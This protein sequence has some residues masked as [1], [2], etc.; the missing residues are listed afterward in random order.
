MKH[1]LSEEVEPLKK[2]FMVIV[3]LPQKS[4]VVH[5]PCRGCA[6][7]TLPEAVFVA[8]LLI[9]RKLDPH[10]KGKPHN[11]F[12]EDAELILKDHALVEVHPR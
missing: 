1:W 9:R 7:Y 4:K 11:L 10:I 6:L 2:Q 12:I 8:H 3:P 5:Y